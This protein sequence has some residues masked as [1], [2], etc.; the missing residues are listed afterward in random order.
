MTDPLD[1]AY[2]ALGAGAALEDFWTNAG[3]DA[4]LPVCGG[5]LEFI[6][7]VIQHAPMLDKIWSQVKDDYAGV[8]AY[9]VAEEVGHSLATRMLATGQL[10]PLHDVEAFIRTAIKPGLLTKE[11]LH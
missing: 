11:T 4:E 9:E 2:L 8:W 7:A 6:R 3:P 1:I 10:V 5:E